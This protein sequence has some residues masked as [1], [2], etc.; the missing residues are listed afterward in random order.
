MKKFIFAVAALAAIMLT[1]CSS[2]KKSGN[3]DGSQ[4]GIGSQTTTSQ[5]VTTTVSQSTTVSSNTGS[6]AT[7]DIDGDGL[8]EEL[9][10]DVNDMVSDVVSGAEGV[11]DDVLDGGARSKR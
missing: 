5:S 2:D 1:G 11:V 6:S 8:L 9:G 3:A 10:T 4:T 7:G